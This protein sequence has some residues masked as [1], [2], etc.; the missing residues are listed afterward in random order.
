MRSHGLRCHEV[1]TSAAAASGFTPARG[2]PPRTRSPPRSEPACSDRPAAVANR[3]TRLPTRG[4]REPGRLREADSSNSD[5]PA[6]DPG[7]SYVARTHGLIRGDH[8]G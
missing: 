5:G 1:S 3:L 2:E 7:E 6:R 4:D 8:P